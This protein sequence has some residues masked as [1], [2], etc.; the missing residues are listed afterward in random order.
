V[1]EARS[2]TTSKHA[3][4]AQRRPS[5]DSTHVE[6]VENEEPDLSYGDDVAARRP[7]RVSVSREQAAATV[8]AVRVRLAALTWLVAL[9]AAI[10]LSLGAMLVAL[11]A[12]TDNALVEGVLNAARAIDGPFWRVFDFYEDTRSGRQ[13]PPDQVKNH[14]VNWGLAAAAYLL[15]GRMLSN[16]IRPAVSRPS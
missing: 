16:L 5:E 7:L 8:K 13:G 1:R 11:N 9:T 6:P 12:N 3:V 2:T 14:L 4:V 15:V 10:V